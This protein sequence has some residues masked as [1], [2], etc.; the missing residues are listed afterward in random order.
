[1]V[2]DYAGLLRHCLLEQ[3]FPKARSKYHEIVLWK[4]V[5]LALFIHSGVEFFVAWG[6]ETEPWCSI[7]SFK[8][9]TSTWNF[10]NKLPGLRSGFGAETLLE[11]LERTQLPEQYLI[12]K[13]KKAPF[14]WDRHFIIGTDKPTGRP[15]FRIL[16]VEKS[17]VVKGRLTDKEFV[18]RKYRHL[19]I[20]AE[21]APKL[22][23]N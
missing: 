9:L 3:A 21:Q 15:A 11:E 16:S 7:H 10:R 23:H 1:M 22:R 17:I 5:G 12:E 13:F 4:S 6:Q 8:D 14:I 18:G 19:E 2:L 20:F